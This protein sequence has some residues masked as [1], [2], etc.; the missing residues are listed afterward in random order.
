MIEQ[1]LY[2]HLIVQPNLAQ[3]LTTY[4][5]NPAVFN[6]EAPADNDARWEDG[7]QYGRVV[8]A[9]DI[10]GDPERT[11]GGMLAVDIQCK[12]NEQFPEVIEPIIRGLIHGW[13]F[14]NGT[15]TV[16]AQWKNSSYFTEPTD[17]VNGCTVTFDLLAFPIMTTGSPDV[18]ARLNEWTAAIDGLHVINYDELPSTAWQPTGTDSAIYWRVVTDTPA[19]W[20][21]D[22]FQTVWRMS[23]VRGHI[24]SQDHATA[25]TVARNIIARLYTAKRLLKAGESPIMV[26]QNNTA[27]YGADPLR[28]GQLSVEATYAII[29]YIEPDK[30]LEHINVKEEDSD[31]WTPITPQ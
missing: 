12:E 3:Y 19:I 14:S 20:I 25:D 4:A 7:S 5:G 11:M 1:A 28:T 17:K 22:T 10:Q 27:D 29:V 18:I 13:F 9:V 2:E 26:N 30:D 31:T 21:P 15:F 24:F 6:Q 16:E 8:F 23:T